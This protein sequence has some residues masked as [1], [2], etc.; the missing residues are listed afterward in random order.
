MSVRKVANVWNSG[1]RSRSLASVCAR[2]LA[3]AVLTP[4]SHQFTGMD[5]MWTNLASTAADDFAPSPINL[6]SRLPRPRLAP[7]NR[8]SKGSHRLSLLGPFRFA[9]ERFAGVR[10][11]SM[12]WA[13]SALG[14]AAQPG[15]QHSSWWAPPARRGRTWRNGWRSL[16]TALDV[17]VGPDA[18]ANGRA[19][20]SSPGYVC[21]SAERPQIASLHWFERANLDNPPIPRRTV[22][23]RGSYSARK[24]TANT[25]NGSRS[26]AW[27]GPGARAR[28]N[29]PC[30][31]YGQPATA[32]LLS[33][34]PRR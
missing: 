23:A 15:W 32:R 4:H 18:R 24:R 14:A 33:R 30:T 6:G 21:Q 1:A 22:R 34:P 29:E 10:A 28:F 31:R 16:R 11:A 17:L 5:S 27:S 3:L 9:L 13:F 26:S 20:T 19:I 12:Q 25:G 7:G 2:A 8:E